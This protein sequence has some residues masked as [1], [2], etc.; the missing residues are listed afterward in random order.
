[1]TDRD[2][3]TTGAAEQVHLPRLAEAVDAALGI[4]AAIVRTV[5]R[6]TTSHPLAPPGDRPLEDI[7][8]YGTTAAGSL[9]GLVVDAARAT[10]GAVTTAAPATPR[11]RPPG[12]AAGPGATGPT[13]T[14]PRVTAGSTLRVPL[15]VE[16]TGADPTPEIAFA[17]TGIERADLAGSEPTDAELPSCATV[18][19][20]PPTLVIGPRDFD[21]LTVRIPTDAATTPGR[22]RA[23]IEGG[24]GWFA[25]DVVF[26]VTPA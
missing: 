16:N 17:A 11:P 9:I 10:A 20:T 14:S 19:F 1:M 21:K 12:G 26:D 24:D 2:E 5:A 7:V 25:T 6:A 13:T 3:P 4:G 23:R 15:L 22:Y 8:R 18:T